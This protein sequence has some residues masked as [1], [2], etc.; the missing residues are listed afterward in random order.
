MLWQQLEPIAQS[1]LLN[2]QGLMSE[3]I[4]YTNP[5]KDYYFETV[6][7]ET[8]FSSQIQF[9]LMNGVISFAHEQ[10]DINAKCDSLINRFKETTC[11][12]TW[13]WPHDMSVPEDIESVFTKHGF[14]SMGEYISIAV[15]GEKV[16][17]LSINLNKDVVIQLVE[18]DKQFFEFIQITQEVYGMPE[19]AVPNMS[20]LYSAYKYTN[21][22]RLYLALVNGK[23]A[24]TLLCY[25]QKN[26]LGIYN[27][28]TLE[29]YRKQGLLTAL[30]IHALKD[31][32]TSDYVVAQLM[33]SQNA[34]GVCDQLGF[35]TYSHFTPFCF[36]FNLDEMHA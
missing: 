17:D 33:A 24:S 21:N 36:G 9:P 28:A 1:I 7:G 18:N 23:P 31:A 11:P 35:K 8:Y 13:F 5:N 4:R 10:N 34:K 25:Q 29:S 22:I 26:I 2:F 30:I 15:E 12:V 6:G 3:C 19:H 27:G 32:P 14:S 16:R 20:R